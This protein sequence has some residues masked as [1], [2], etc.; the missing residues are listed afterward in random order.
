MPIDPSKTLAA[1]GNET[2]ASSAVIGQEL[3]QLRDQVDAID[4]QI[5]EL[6]VKRIELA[7]LIMKSKRGS[8]LVDSGRERSIVQRYSEKL[9]DLSTV[10]KTQKL[11][12]GIIEASK[13]YPDA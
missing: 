4:D 13:F 9:A 10:A 2:A 1:N 3:N 11:V 12:S 6:M 5:I 8:Q 7:T